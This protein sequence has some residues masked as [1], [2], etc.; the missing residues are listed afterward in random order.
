[1][2]HQKELS[3]VYMNPIHLTDQYIIYFLFVLKRTMDYFK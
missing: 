2:E 1:M 3:I